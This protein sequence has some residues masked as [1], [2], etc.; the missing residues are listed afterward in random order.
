M[1][2]H[3]VELYIKVRTMK[4]GGVNK[5]MHVCTLCPGKAFTRR[6]HA[7]VH[8]RAHCGVKPY[9]CPWTNCVSRGAPRT[10]CSPG[11]GEV[12]RRLIEEYDV[13]LEAV[14]DE[15]KDVIWTCAE[16]LETHP[17]KKNAHASYV[18]QMAFLKEVQQMML[19][20]RYPRGD[21]RNK[22]KK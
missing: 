9:L 6:G 19:R 1:V 17:G 14:D 21:G 5:R 22:K 11:A 16:A 2:S 15:K 7:D 12:C 20:T 3:Y 4:V 18:K 13:D 10:R 8:I